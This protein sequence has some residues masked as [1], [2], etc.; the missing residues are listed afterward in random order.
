MSNKK[1]IKVDIKRRYLKEGRYDVLCRMMEEMLH[2]ATGKIHTVD[3]HE[4]EDGT[5]KVEFVAEG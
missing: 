1:I 3:Y 2:A 5:V 4:T